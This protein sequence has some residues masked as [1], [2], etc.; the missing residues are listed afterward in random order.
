MPEMGNFLQNA[1]SATMPNSSNRFGQPPIT[2]S[3]RDLQQELMMTDFIAQKVREQ[4]FSLPP[5]GFDAAHAN[6]SDQLASLMPMGGSS[7]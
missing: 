4:N 3:D 2:I 1:F 5:R 7:R 6:V